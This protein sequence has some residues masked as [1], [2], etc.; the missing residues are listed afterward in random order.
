MVQVLWPKTGGWKSKRE[1]KMIRS[2]AWKKETHFIIVL[3]NNC[4]ITVSY[5]GLQ[6]ANVLLFFLTSGGNIML[7][8]FG[9]QKETS[10]LDNKALHIGMR[11]YPKNTGYV[12][13]VSFSQTN[14]FKSIDPYKRFFYV[15]FWFSMLNWC[16]WCSN[17]DVFVLMWPKTHLY[18]HLC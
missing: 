2:I 4:K 14:P 11:D 5:F 3:K 9:K 1:A 17:D 18:F 15:L 10:T 13:L 6:S 12:V 16:G 8:S 7:I